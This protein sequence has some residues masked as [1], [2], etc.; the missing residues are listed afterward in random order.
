MLTNLKVELLDPVYIKGN[1]REE[2]FKALDKL[3]DAI[4]LKHKERGYK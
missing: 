4:A 1:P 3:A 2:D